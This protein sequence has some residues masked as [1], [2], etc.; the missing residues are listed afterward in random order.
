MLATNTSYNDQ[1]WSVMMNRGRDH[2][3]TLP[4]ARG[5]DEFNWKEGVAPGPMPA[6]NIK[7]DWQ[8]ETKEA[9]LA[10]PDMLPTGVRACP[11]AF[12]QPPRP[13]SAMKSTQNW[14]ISNKRKLESD[15]GV[16]ARIASS[17]TSSALPG[18]PPRPDFPRPPAHPQYGEVLTASWS[19]SNNRWTYT[20]A[21]GLE[22]CSAPMPAPIG[23][24]RCLST[25]PPS[26]VV[27]HIIAEQ[28]ACYAERN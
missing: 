3:Y 24:V 13:S 7:A 9:L 11:R 17:T 8:G 1:A 14:A 27:N 12:L 4:A 21:S 25:V 5:R 15:P 6:N 22:F 23:E 26:V 16:D 10:K 2:S 19:Y 20:Y 28:Q 18:F